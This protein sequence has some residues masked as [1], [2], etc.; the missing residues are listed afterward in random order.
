[1][2]SLIPKILL[3]KINDMKQTGEYFYCGI[4][5]WIKYCL[6]IQVEWLQLSNTDTDDICVTPL[7]DVN[8]VSCNCSNFPA[9]DKVLLP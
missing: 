9:S 7:Q 2:S 3:K 6:Q 4:L 1:M 8:V 5:T